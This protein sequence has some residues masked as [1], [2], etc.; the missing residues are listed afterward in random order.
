MKIAH[1]LADLAHYAELTPE[2]VEPVIKILAASEL[3]VIQ[4]IAA[5]GTRPEFYEIFHDVLAPAILDWRARRLQAQELA[6]AKELAE[7]EAA[8]RKQ[9]RAR[10][11]H[12][13]EA[14]LNPFG[15]KFQWHLGPSQRIWLPP[16]LR[17]QRSG[18][19]CWFD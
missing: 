16:R 9:I 5:S 15:L 11:R 3:R 17:K 18:S 13:Y 8:E 1:S 2:R 4:V 12:G 19:V 6:E 14:R 10:E 7:L